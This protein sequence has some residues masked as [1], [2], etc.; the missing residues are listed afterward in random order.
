MTEGDLVVLHEGAPE[1]IPST[2]ST[3]STPSA[4]RSALPGHDA[5]TLGIASTDGLAL[6]FA[7]M[8]APAP[9]A[10]ATAM[11]RV[12]ALTLAIVAWMALLAAFGLYGRVR[13][14][15]GDDIRRIA[16]A[17]GVVTVVSVLF[18]ADDIVGNPVFGR[19]LLVLFGLLTAGRLTWRAVVRRLEHRGH[20]ALRTLVVGDV[21]GAIAAD[22]RASGSDLVPIGHVSVD[23]SNEPRGGLPVL[24]TVAEL[25]H[26]V[27][28]Y[29]ADCILVA[30]QAADASTLD[31]VR[32][33]ARREGVQLRLL[34][35]APDVLP[36]RL[37]VRPIAG[38]VSVDVR[39]AKLSGGQAALKRAA[40]V[41]GAFVGLVVLSPLL[42]VVALVVRLTSPGPVLFRQVRATKGGRAFTIYKFR[43][44]YVDVDQRL[45]DRGIDKREAFFKPRI[46]DLVTPVG[47]VLRRA[48]LDEFP[49]LWNILRG[50]M[51]LVGPRP[52][53]IE[54]VEANPE[55]LG[56]RHDMR[57]GLTGWWQVNGR[58][59]VTP[60]EAVRQDQFY[61]ENWT[62]GLDI[63]ILAR[64]I[65]VLLGRRGAR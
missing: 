26:V 62:L 27:R 31:L 5:V 3:P 12:G 6:C 37:G 21:E 50:D 22:L 29:L 13:R 20:L 52:L 16:A 65:G 35:P 8:A 38:Y 17:V 1:G 58:S 36:S 60:D 23:G 49:Q 10:P 43:T 19:G 9:I 45:S 7:L 42:L 54:Q 63:A 61:V 24:G 47:R 25:Q 53:P 51:S 30:P 56:P 11:A 15:V 55:L 44:M 28:R 34:T 48:S 57:T 4:Q 18:L 46:E 2:S 39:N 41:V 59:D 64:T 14:T 40:D 33:A 32:R